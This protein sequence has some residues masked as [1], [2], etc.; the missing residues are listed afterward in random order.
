LRTFTV[1]DPIDVIPVHFGGGLWGLFAS[2][3]LKNDAFPGLNGTQAGIYLGYNIIG[4]ISI[5]A[6]A[7]GC[8]TVL[9]GFLKLANL[10]RSTQQEE[11]LGM[12]LAK[13]NE[14][15]YRLTL[16]DIDLGEFNNLR[17]SKKE[18]SLVVYQY[19]LAF[20]SHKWVL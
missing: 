3:L 14:P 5:M 1:D 15:A 18:R 12:D 19:F 6:W 2:P 7:M 8:S 9:F 20:S 16:K 10:I 4:A 13:H 17:E 11:I